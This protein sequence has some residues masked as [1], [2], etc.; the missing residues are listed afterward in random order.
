MKKKNNE[1]IDFLY[2]LQ[3]TGIK[4]GIENIK[5][6][7]DEYSVDYEKMKIIHIAGTNGKGSTSNIL[8]SLLKNSGYKC[9][10]FTSPHLKEF[11]E[12][13]RINDNQI[14]NEDLGNLTSYFK[15]GILRNNCTFFEATTAIT[16]KYFNDNEVDFVILETG[17]GGRLD[18]TNVV[19]PVLSVITG[20]DYDH[21]SFLGNSLIEIT[22]EKCG[23]IKENTPLVLNTNKKFVFKKVSS[24]AKQKNARLYYAR[25]FKI[26]TTQS[27]LNGKATV[28]NQRFLNG[29][30]TVTPQSFLNG[31]E[32]RFKLKGKFLKTYF[33]L[34]GD[35]Q[36]YN[37]KTAL[38]AF[39]CLKD[40]KL[41]QIDLKNI[42]KALELVKVKGRMEYI[43]PSILLDAGHNKEGLFAVKRELEKIKKKIYI[44]LGTVKDK[45]YEQY[46]KIM[47]SMPGEKHFA[48][49][50]IP[51]G[52][53]IETIKKFFN[54]NKNIEN[55]FFH[56]SVED[57]YNE[58]KKRVST[59][60]LIVVTGSHYI[61][62]D[63]LDYYED[64]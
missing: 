42:A 28:T 48:E 36:I 51:R 38:T 50:K 54:S 8:Y 27:F 57:A 15:D 52:L 63:F 49:P 10:V 33:N 7:L 43:E 6:L 58:V 11:N 3:L 22:K 46:L 18:S 25:K 17:L 55:C 41:V 60:D 39:L 62:G 26:V 21:L 12:R 4:L 32:I 53:S 13:I 14:T 5:K 1:V 9:G 35:Y 45:D 23:I 24:I 19:K 47:S 59:K 61:I 40:L 37:L 34:N 29:K 64:K 31:K 16:L 56:S 44:I 20:I 30:E 2:G